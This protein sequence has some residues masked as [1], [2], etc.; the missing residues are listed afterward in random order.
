[1]ANSQPRQCWCLLF[2][3]FCRMWSIRI[4]IIFASQFPDVQRRFI[5]ELQSCYIVEYNS[6]GIS[7]RNKEQTLIV[8][9]RVVP[10]SQLLNST[11]RHI[12]FCKHLQN[13]YKKPLLSD[14]TRFRVRGTSSEFS[15][16][17]Q[18]HERITHHTR[19][20]DCQ[21]PRFLIG[22]RKNYGGF[23]SHGDI[24]K[25]LHGFSW[26]NSIYIKWM[27]LGV[28]LWLGK[29]PYMKR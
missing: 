28:P 11:V 24:P 8:S 4:A 13:C 18:Q 22:F 17:L 14:E 25:T 19:T 9:W 5:L 26:K 7:S 6:Y 12:I 15:Q 23:H 16:P 2:L 29:S 21:T 3:F 1:M 20:S 10:W 27:I